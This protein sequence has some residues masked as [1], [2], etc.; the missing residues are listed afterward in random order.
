MSLENISSDAY[1]STVD[2]MISLINRK[3]P[4]EMCDADTLER[5]MDEVLMHF[6]FLALQEEKSNS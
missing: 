6:K 5:L 1:H 2:A 3:M 4:K